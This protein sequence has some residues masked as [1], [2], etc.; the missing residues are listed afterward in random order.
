MISSGEYFVL[1]F[2]QNF[3]SDKYVLVFIECLKELGITYK[4][5]GKI[6]FITP[7]DGVIRRNNMKKE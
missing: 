1:D 7:S 3:S 5:S 4:Y 6:E 2:K